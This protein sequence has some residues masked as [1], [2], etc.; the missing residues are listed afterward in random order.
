MVMTS[1][2]AS[3]SQDGGKWSAEGN[4]I[5]ITF[6]EDT[7]EFQYSDGKMSSN[8]FKGGYFVKK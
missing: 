5:Y 2:G 3:E 1:G 7:E 4:S 6:D 8:L